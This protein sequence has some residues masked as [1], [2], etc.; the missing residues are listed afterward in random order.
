MEADLSGANISTAD[1]TGAALVKADSSLEL[2]SISLYAAKMAGYAKGS[3]PNDVTAGFGQ[4]E[5]T[6]EHELGHQIDYKLGISREAHN[7]SAGVWSELGELAM[8][9]RDPKVQ[10]GYR[11]EPAYLNILNSCHPYSP[12]SRDLLYIT[13][14]EERMANLFNAYWY[15]PHLPEEVAPR[16]NKWFRDY[17]AAQAGDLVID[18]IT[19]VKPSLLIERATS[20]PMYWRMCD[21]NLISQNTRSTENF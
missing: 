7:R 13:S 19:S 2:K 10:A 16:A 5:G 18:A 4:H 21:I 20:V 9:R 1:L 17:L 3:F 6:L 14:A 11:R 8:L 15:A 12:G